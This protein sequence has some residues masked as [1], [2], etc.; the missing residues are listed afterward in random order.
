MKRKILAA[1]LFTCIMSLGLVGCGKTASQK[2]EADAGDGVLQAEAKGVVEIVGTDDFQISV[3]EG[4]TG[5]AIE[6]T[7]DVYLGN[8]PGGTNTAEVQDANMIV[9]NYADTKVLPKG[10]SYFKLEKMKRQKTDIREIAEGAAKLQDD[11]TL[12]RSLEESTIGELWPDL[13][14]EELAGLTVYHVTTEIRDNDFMFEH[15]FFQADGMNMVAGIFYPR[16]DEST[17]RDM[18]SQFSGVEFLKK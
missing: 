15:F 9:V 1:V 13:S 6:D 7:E 14:S 2:T 11:D 8:E 17:R 5:R 18:M 4:Y 10:A 3:G 12:K 16:G